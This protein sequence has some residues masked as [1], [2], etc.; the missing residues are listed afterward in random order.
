[1]RTL[2]LATLALLLSGCLRSE[3][4]F[5]LKADGSGTLRQAYSVDLKARLELAQM[6]AV[7]YGGSLDPKDLPFANPVAPEWLEALAERTPGYRIQKAKQTE[8]KA[9]RTTVV[10]A[11]FDDLEA[12]ADAGAFFTSAV[13]L[14]AQGE[15][16]WKLTLRD[17]WKDAS[18]R[19]PRDLG[20]QNVKAL[21]KTFEAQLGGLVFERTITVPTQVI[22]T[23]GDLDDLGTKVTWKVDYVRLLEGNDLVLTITF[24]NTDDL[25]LKPFRHEPRMKALMVRCLEAPPGAVSASTT[26]TGEEAPADATPG[27]DAPVTPSEPEPAAPAPAE[28]AG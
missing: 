22:A 1:M 25:D 24:R 4:E 23:N 8:T 21:L 5:V 7:L 27:D 13:T 18:G 3:E 28:E 9:K 15:D 17:A 14:E 26:P 12:A 19:T 20:G 16:A 6:A 11:A 2:V 10:E